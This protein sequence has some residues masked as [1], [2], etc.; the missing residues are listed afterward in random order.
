MWN[1]LYK[2]KNFNEIIG[3]Q[4]LKDSIKKYKWEKP[5]ILY[6]AVGVGKSVF[7][8]AVATEFKWELVEITDENINDADRIA[9]TS[10]LFGTKKLVVIDNIEKIR[11]IKK[12]TDFVKQTKNPAILITSDFKNKRL[13]SIKRYCNKLQVMRPGS[14]VVSKILQIICK[15][16]G[17]LAENEILIKIAENVKG[18][19]RAAINDLETIAEPGEKL[20]KDSL[21]ILSGRDI[22]VDIS[23]AM[24]VIFKAGE[25]E[26]AVNIMRDLNEMPRDIMPWIDEI[27]PKVYE[28]DEITMGFYY[29]SRA[30]RFIRRIQKQQY[31]GFLRYA[32]PLMSGGVALSKK[33]P[34]KHFNYYGQFPQY[35]AKMGRTKRERN[36][37]DSIGGKLHVLHVSKK[38]GARE[39][40]PLFKILLKTGKIKEEKLEEKFKFNYD[41]I[42]YLK[43]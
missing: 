29:L 15:N 21:K 31:W 27:L 37:K 32:S 11:D 3:S 8:N 22:S 28:K 2:P 39:F 42:E 19:I 24:E 20:T 43:G 38:V 14:I 40:I 13:G 35:W 41:E 6:G 26:P 33:H 7:V 1:E 17:I 4:N 10:T 23:K 5:L 30:D 16:E 9:T 34:P 18:D 25:L 36:L 12:I